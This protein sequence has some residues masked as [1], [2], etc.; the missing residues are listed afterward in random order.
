[1]KKVLIKIKGTLGLD[2]ED[3][4]FELVTEGILKRF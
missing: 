4:V 1:M 2:G 3:A